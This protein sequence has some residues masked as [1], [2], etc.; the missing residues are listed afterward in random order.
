[1]RAVTVAR[2]G[3][4]E[5]LHVG[6][7]DDPAPGAGEILIDVRATGVN[8]ADLLQRA[9]GY[10]P[11]PGASRILGLEAA[12]VV[13]DLGP[14]AAGPPVGTGV[15]ALLAGGGYAER[16]AV[17]GGQVMPVPDGMSMTDAAAIPEAFLTAW[18]SLRRLTSLTAGESLLIHAAASGVGLA[19]GQIA[20]ALGATTVGHDPNPGQGRS[21]R[22]RRRDADRDRPGRTIRRRRPRCD[23]GPRRGRGARH[24]RGRVLG[25]D[26]RRAGTRRARVGDRSPRRVVGHGRARARSCGARRPSPSAPCGREASTRSPIWWRSSQRWAGPRF[27]AGEL[28]P[29]VD[30]VMAI[31]DVADAHRLMESNANTGKIVLTL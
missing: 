3:G 7:V 5:V 10:P 29:S 9:G 2:P 8:R 21:G 17:P 20:G 25:R 18:L 24:G 31:D 11:P 1:M 26:R 6:V 27:A 14:D 15:M 13:A 23:R 19:A 16:V 28:A 22:G 4:P 30:R 12:G